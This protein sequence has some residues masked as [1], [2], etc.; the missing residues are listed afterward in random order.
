MSRAERGKIMTQ[1]RNPFRLKGAI[2]FLISGVCFFAPMMTLAQSQTLN[3]QLAAKTTGQKDRLLVEA[4]EMVY[5]K[6]NNTVSATGDVE[7]NYQGRT[8]QADKVTYNRTTNRVMAQGNARLIETNGNVTTG[9]KF[10]LTD[11]FKEGFIDSLRSEGKDKTRFSAPRAER[12]AGETTI[13]DQG[14]YTACE[15]CK[16]NPSKPPLWQ[17]KAKRIIHNNEEKMVYYE[18]ATLEF[19][20]LP[21]A[22]FP[23]MSS[24]DPTV[25]RK[26]G[27]LA[28]RYSASSSLGTGIATPF[29]WALAP[30]Y[31]LTLTPT[32]YSRQGPL[33]QVEW[34]HRFM[35]GS[36]NIRAAGIFQRDQEAFLPAPLGARNKDA[37]GSVETTGRFFINDKWQ[38]GW[39]VAL[40]SD[41]WFLTNYRI[42]SESLTSNYFKESTST[43]YLTGKGEG[44]YFDARG[45]YFQP[46][47]YADWQKQQP[48]VHPVIDYNKRVQNF[49]DTGGE[50]TVDANITSLS[51]DSAQFQNLPRPGGSLINFLSS[52]GQTYGVY[53]GCTVYQKGQCL[54]RGIGGNYSRATAQVSWRKNVIDPLG[55]VW[56][57]YASLRADGMWIAPDTSRYQNANQVNFFDTNSDFVGRAMPTAGLMYRFPFVATDGPLK[58]THILEPI[59][60]IAV[61]PNEGNIGRLPNED[62]QSLVFDDTT[63]FDWNKFSGYDRVEGG[64]RANAGL[65]YTV[66]TQDG[67]FA[68][69]L[70]GQSY[71]VAGRNS[72]EKPDLANTGLNSGLESRRSDYVGRFH[73]A[74]MANMSFTARGRWDEK[75]T[76]LRR[77]ELQ[78]NASF[79]DVTTN[80]IYARYAAQ[81]DL[82]AYHRKEGIY[83]S[84]SYKF[85]PNWYVNGSVLF[86]MDRYLTQRDVFA[87]SPTTV[88]YKG[89]S[90]YPASLSAGFGYGDECT[91]FSVNY[92]TQYRDA[93]TGAKQHTQ[94]VLLRLELRTLGQVGFKQNFGQVSAQDG[95]SQ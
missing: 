81:P 42:R 94:T 33:A 50:L 5:N 54:M 51:R 87:A 7:L 8:L 67:A 17:V 71:N 29:F 31:D 18:N 92:S 89:S 80:L 66:K 37:R 35:S 95:I 12:V 3:D 62:S 64:V 22:Y 19:W 44:G 60:Q 84:A 4:R 72:F 75:T 32:Y 79:G 28:P 15:P 1:K 55:Q 68:N 63:I 24:P 85:T 49:M 59:A 25:K 70:F 10:E 21:V 36:Y 83:A 41:K 86:D 20:G 6:D 11:D 56:T 26:T 13:F 90:F 39:D 30:H 57:P 88:A 23:Y 91:I 38:T 46:L 52:N 47:S 16:D 77:V 14:T 9:D 93:A 78:A 82:G 45:Y 58:S 76:D 43:A 2:A 74:P 53:E 65:Q 61:R 40:L 27:F 73:I 69:L 48:I 34:R